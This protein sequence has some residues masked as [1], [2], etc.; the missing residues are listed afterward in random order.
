MPYAAP[1]KSTT[2][3]LLRP[4]RRAN[5]SPA[6]ATGSE[7][8]ASAAYTSPSERGGSRLRNSASRAVSSSVC[9]A[10]S[11]KYVPAAAAS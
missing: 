8:S 3:A 5:R 1:S 2:S 4:K 6:I 9:P 7:A 11:K 10:M